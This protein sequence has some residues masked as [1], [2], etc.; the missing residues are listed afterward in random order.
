MRYATITLLVL[1]SL[2]ALRGE[3]LGVLFFVA[4]AVAGH[5]GATMV[6]KS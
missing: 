2:Q 5:V 4:L 6:R 1:A 3:Y